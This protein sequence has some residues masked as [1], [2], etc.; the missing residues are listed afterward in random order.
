MGN[1]NFAELPMIIIKWK[2]NKFWQTLNDLW[3]IFWNFDKMFKFS[4]ISLF[5]IPASYTVKLLPLPITYLLWTMKKAREKV[6]FNKNKNNFIKKI[7]KKIELGQKVDITE[8]QYDYLP[9]ETQDKLKNMQ[10]KGGN[11]LLDM[12]S[13]K[14]D[15]FELVLTAGLIMLIFYFEQVPKCS[16]HMEDKIKNLKKDVAELEKEVEKM[17]AKSGDDKKKDDKKKD[18]QKKDDKKKDDKKKDKPEEQAM[19]LEDEDKKDKKKD[20]NKKDD[21][22]KDDKKKDDKKKDDKKKK[23]KENFS[24]KDLD[25]KREILNN[26]SKELEKLESNWVSFDLTKILWDGFMHV[27][28]PLGFYIFLWYVM[29]MIVDPFGIGPMF[30]ILTRIP[31]IPNLLFGGIMCLLYN[32]MRNLRDITKRNSCFDKEAKTLL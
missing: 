24:V 15:I 14:P 16:K 31:V 2:I 12:F 9:Q 17:E 1:I 7:N 32:M 22:K 27:I 5:L 6:Q 28:T 29:P 30:K 18:D 10:K 8:E 11:F 19:T 4:P 26:R 3:L 25:K 20:D 21:K 13:T 23:K